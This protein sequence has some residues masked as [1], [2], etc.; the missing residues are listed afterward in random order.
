M[1]VMDAWSEDQ[2]VGLKSMVTMMADTGGP[3]TKAVDME[4]THPGPV[5]AL[6]PGRCKRWAAV[7]D[8]GKCS[9]LAVSEAD[10]DPAGDD[11]PSATLAEAVL[12][13]V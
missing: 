11:D 6:G 7:F 5:G 12:A 4:M 1:A 9:W 8:D 10:G 13:A 3:F 2:G